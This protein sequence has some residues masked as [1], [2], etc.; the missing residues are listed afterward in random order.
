MVGNGGCQ[1]ICNNY[2]GRYTC[3]CREGFKLSAVDAKSCQGKFK[4]LLF[5]YNLRNSFLRKHSIVKKSKA[6]VSKLHSDYWGD[7]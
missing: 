7:L 4:I 6:I 5:L 2:A 1:H 3:V